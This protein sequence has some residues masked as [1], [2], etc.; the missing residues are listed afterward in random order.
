LGIQGVTQRDGFWLGFSDYCSLPD[1]IIRLLLNKIN[2]VSDPIPTAVKRMPFE[3]KKKFFP[4]FLNLQ[5]F[6]GFSHILEEV[7]DCNTRCPSI[8]KPTFYRETEQGRN[9]LNCH[10]LV[11]YGTAEL[12]FHNLWYDLNKAKYCS[13]PALPHIDRGLL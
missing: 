3:I 9:Q 13:P 10:D 6:T 1:Q 12:E 8:P 2:G 5:N 11:N 4:L 7:G